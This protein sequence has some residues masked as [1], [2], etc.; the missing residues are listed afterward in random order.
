M[1]LPAGT[2]YL[3]DG[4]YYWYD[5]FQI[6]LLAYNG[7]VITNKVALDFDTLKSF[8]RQPEVQKLI[9]KS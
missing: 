6:W 2:E 5:G 3:G 7:I 8:L 4:L 1:N 9:K